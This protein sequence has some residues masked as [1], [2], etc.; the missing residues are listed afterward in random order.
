MSILTH[1]QRRG[2]GEEKQ[3]TG[4]RV[5]GSCGLGCCK[6]RFHNGGSPGVGN[7]YERAGGKAGRKKNGEARVRSGSGGRREVDTP[8]RGPERK[9]M[10]NALLTSREEA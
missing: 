10:K 2:E 3:Q 8:E 4:V 7:S 6:R 1:A 9:L 5:V